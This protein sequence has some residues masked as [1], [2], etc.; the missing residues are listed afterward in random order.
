MTNK[1]LQLCSFEQAKRLKEL[2]FNWEIKN[3]YFYNNK[4]NVFS[5][6]TGKDYDW[7]LLTHFQDNRISAP[8]IALALKWCRDVKNTKNCVC[9][10][11]Y[12]WYICIQGKEH[13]QG[14]LSYESAENASLDEL[15][16]TV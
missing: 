7:N 1:Q 11:K 12:G 4:N 16:N 10:G 6:V 2:G 13:G 8:T 5:T 14:Y 9:F 3:Y 15:L